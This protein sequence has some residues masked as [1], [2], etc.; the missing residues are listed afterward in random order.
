LHFRPSLFTDL[1][2]AVTAIQ[3]RDLTIGLLEAYL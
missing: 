1:Q 2:A 3:A